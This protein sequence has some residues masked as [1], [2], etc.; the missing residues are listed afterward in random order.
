M[1]HLWE[2]TYDTGYDEDLL[3]Q[4]A[5]LVFMNRKRVESADASQLGLAFASQQ[6]TWRAIR[7]VL[8]LR[9]SYL[10]SK[11]IEDLR[12]VLTSDERAELTKRVRAE[13]E[14]SEE[15]RALQDTDADK[16]KAKG[17]GWEG[18]GAAGKGKAK[19]KGDVQ[20]SLTRGAPQ[21]ATGSLATFLRAQKR[22]RWC[23]HLQRVC[24]TKQ[25]WEILAFTG[26]FDADILRQAVC[27]SEQEG[28]AEEEAQD[29]DQQQRRRLLHAKA[30][31]R[32]RYNEGRRLAGQRD[33]HRDRLR[34]ASQP[35]REA[36][37]SESAPSVTS[38]QW[39]MLQRWDSGELLRKYN[40]AIAALGHGR[41]RSAHGALLDI[42]GSTGGES[43][44]LIDGWVP[45]D[46]REFLPHSDTA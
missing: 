42:G 2:E 21:P 45:P 18:K 1:K 34:G 5:R 46:W 14:N 37:S 26:R 27:S 6:E 20:G 10:K 22:K 12:H 13:Y 25:I 19:S 17:K 7:D 31:A 33:A 43:R 39:Y 3:S 28:H 24:G 30:E 15:Q 29:E 41:L 32:A 40:N 36:G 38:W 4:L 44:R 8:E 16:G 11:G 23:R 9:Q 35:A